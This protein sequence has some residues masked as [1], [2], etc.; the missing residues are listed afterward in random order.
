MSSHYRDI[1]FSLSGN[2]IRIN[3][4]NYYQLIKSKDKNNYYTYFLVLL[5][6]NEG[7]FILKSKT[8]NIFSGN[9]LF[10]CSIEK[11]RDKLCFYGGAFDR[12]PVYDELYIDELFK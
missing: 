8:R 2:L 12:Y 3:H 7:T 1:N 11:N 10:I 9:K 5:E 4:N 6:Y